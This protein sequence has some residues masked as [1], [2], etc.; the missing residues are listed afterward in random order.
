MKTFLKCLN[1][2][3][4]HFNFIYKMAGERSVHHQRRPP[5]V[6]EALSS[7]L[8][9]P[10]E[11]SS[12]DTSSDDEDERIQRNLKSSYVS[13]CSDYTANRSFAALDTEY[14]TFI[15]TSMATST[16]ANPH[17]L[18]DLTSAAATTCYFTAAGKSF[19][20]PLANVATPLVPLPY[21]SVVLNTRTPAVTNYCN[22]DSTLKMN[23]AAHY[24]EHPYYHKASSTGNDNISYTR[25]ENATPVATRQSNKPLHSRYAAIS[26]LT[27]WW[28]PPANTAT[29]GRSSSRSAATIT[30]SSSIMA[31][32]SSLTLSSNGIVKRPPSYESLYAT[33]K[34]S[35]HNNHQHLHLFK[36]ML[37]T[38]KANVTSITQ[39][40]PLT[41]LT[42][43]TAEMMIIQ[44]QD[45]QQ[46]QQ[47]QQRRANI[48]TNA[49]YNTE[50]HLVRSF[51]DDFIVERCAAESRVPATNVDKQHINLRNAV[52]DQINSYNSCNNTQKSHCEIFTMQSLTNVKRISMSH[53]M[54]TNV[55]SQQNQENE[56]NNHTGELQEQ[57]TQLRT[58]IEKREMHALT[59][60]RDSKHKE[61][62]QENEHK[63]DQLYTDLVYDYA[64]SSTRS[65][66]G[67]TLA[68]GYTRNTYDTLKTTGGLVNVLT[69]NSINLTPDNKCL[70]E[71]E[72]LYA[73][74]RASEKIIEQQLKAKA[75][76]TNS[77][78]KLFDTDC[79]N[80]R[81]NV[82]AST[83]AFNRN[84]VN[85]TVK[86]H[87][88][89][90]SV[91]LTTTNSVTALTTNE[92]QHSPSLTIQVNQNNDKNTA[93]NDNKKNR[94]NDSGSDA[95]IKLLQNQN[96]SDKK[97]LV[98]QS[99]VNIITTTTTTTTTNGVSVVNCNYGNIGSNNENN[100]KHISS[101]N[102]NNDNSNNN[103]NN[104]NNQ[105]ITSLSI[106]AF[107]YIQ[108]QQQQQQQNT[109]TH[110]INGHNSKAST[111]T[112]AKHL[113]NSSENNQNSITSY[114]HSGNSNDSN[115]NKNNSSN[116]NDNSISFSLVPNLYNK[117]Y[118]AMN[119]VKNENR[120]ANDECFISSSGNYNNHKSSNSINNI[121]VNIIQ[122]NATATIATV[123]TAASTNVTIAAPAT[124]TTA[125]IP[126]RTFTST[127][128]QT[129]DIPTVKLR[130]TATYAAANAS[131]IPP[132]SQHR[133]QRRRERRERRYLA[134]N[135]SL[136]GQIPTALARGHFRHTPTYPHHHHPQHNH[137]RLL[138]RHSMPASHLT[139][140]LHP[141][142]MHAAMTGTH[143]ASLSHQSTPSPPPPPSPATMLRPTLPDI[144]HNHFPPPY[145]AL[146]CGGSQM[147]NGTTMALAA[148]PPLPSPPLHGATILGSASPT[149]PSSAAG[150]TILTSVIS[151]VPMPGATAI[152]NDGR[153]SLP[154]PIIRRSPSERSGKGCCG[155]WF[156]GPPLR[157][158]IAV[159]AL[160]GVACALAGAGVGFTGV[161]GPPNSHL[162]AALLMIDYC[163]WTVIVRV[164]L[165]VGVHHRLLIVL[166][167]EVY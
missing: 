94:F 61:E 31:P 27:K 125:I 166:M 112:T 56:I 57:V 133:D 25:T 134:H 68:V 152:V 96:Q 24:C 22:D 130:S 17:E 160:G 18:S 16:T 126:K 53:H 149:P 7:M 51:T 39:T 79:A 10:Y 135:N 6:E 36:P 74:F 62:K 75:Y 145:S 120:F 43:T 70:A 108:Q 146:P 37:N 78:L 28:S 110:V 59:C 95:N 12:T 33:T 9:T 92:C 123:S 86:P 105:S 159:V 30:E 144:L 67:E 44:Q 106:D 15:P 84:G 76:D 42:E 99:N 55:G 19:Y 66:D 162:T 111:R 103:I 81:L 20:E 151:T 98:H 26:S 124:T 121:K 122:V 32:I 97:A 48:S 29:N 118:E 40:R 128:C 50:R 100:N 69:N 52:S 117:S 157:A 154:L 2:L 137:H 65:F 82:P 13:F 107:K 142:H 54:D 87:N 141:A 104:H 131:T 138:E 11:R 148:P 77:D 136:L 143:L 45:E 163:Y 83:E 113:T 161:A 116:N 47:E 1:F 115:N 60:A 41:D 89:S 23:G 165:C 119:A 139:A 58:P 109:T 90:N 150:T 156:A 127:E 73:E 147:S 38:L 132:H 4:K 88:S 114:Y 64:I 140:L 5:D 80:M 164:V 34:S 167:P 63:N 14:V 71:L 21:S 101:N 46:Q 93:N 129:D 153:F 102:N 91:I 158:L 3:S 8:W 35:Y 72:R 155:Q 49:Y 85:L